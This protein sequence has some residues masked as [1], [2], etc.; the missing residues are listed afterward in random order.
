MRKTFIFL[1]KHFTAA[2][3]VVGARCRGVGTDMAGTIADDA[4]VATLYRVAVERT[5][6]ASEPCM[7]KRE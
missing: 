2:R 7:V 4:V 5:S 1:G 6:D 3:Q